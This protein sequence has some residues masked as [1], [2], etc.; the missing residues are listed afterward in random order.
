[1]VKAKTFMDYQRIVEDVL[2]PKFGKISLGK[3]TAGH[4]DAFL[5]DMAGMGLSPSSIAKYKAVLHHILDKAM[6]EGII[7]KN[8]VEHST[9][10]RQKVSN[11]CVIS[12]EDCQVLLAEAKNISLNA[13]SQ[14]KNYGQSFFIYPILLTAYHTGMRVGE[15]FAL[16]WKNVDLRAKVIH[17]RENLSEAK[18]EDGKFDL[19]LTT[20]KTGASVR[21]IDISDALCKVLGEIRPH[22]PETGIVFCTRTGGYIAPSNF[23]RVW[24]KLLEKLDMKGKYTIHEWRHTHAT[25]LMSKGIN[26]V[27]ISK[28]LGHAKPQTTISIYTHAVN[29]DGR[30][31]AKVFDEDAP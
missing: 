1:M 23:A 28:R 3:L 30:R 22:A 16:R 13:A 21:D 15:I 17:V 18:N 8:P 2:V 19:L 26:P 25:L 6:A 9:P 14:G 7:S 20:P 4:I 10:V 5:A 31:M 11:R 24:R 29:A 27:S 12:E